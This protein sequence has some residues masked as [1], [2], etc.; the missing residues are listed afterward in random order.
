[1]ADD[2]Y[3]E[4]LSIVK[5]AGILSSVEGVIGWD[6]Q[7]MMPKGEAA[8]RGMQMGL[9]STLVHEMFTQERVGELLT[10]LESCELDETQKAQV[11]ETR[12][13]YDN[14]NFNNM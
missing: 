5:K 1:M 10:E 13:D 12:Q 6:Q 4:L 9:L 3:E 8:I 14:K 2:K 11:R 7:T